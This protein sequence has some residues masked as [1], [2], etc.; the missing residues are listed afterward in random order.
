MSDPAEP[1]AT[2]PL[3]VPQPDRLSQDHPDYEAILRA[4][5]AALDA[6]ADTYVDPPSGLTVLTADY[7]ARRGFCCNSGCRH[8]PY[9]I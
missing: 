8:C 7:L 4:H 9:A 5:A 2:R 6:G 3:T 1:L